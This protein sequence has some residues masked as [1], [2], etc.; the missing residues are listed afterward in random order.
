MLI[1]KRSTCRTCGEGRRVPTRA[2]SYILYE[3]CILDGAVPHRVCAIGA[4][5]GI[6]KK[7]LVLRSWLARSGGLQGA[8]GPGCGPGREA[9]AAR[10]D[11]ARPL[12][13]RSLYE[14]YLFPRG[15]L[16]CAPSQRRSLNNADSSGEMIASRYRTTIFFFADPEAES[17]RR[18]GGADRE[19]SR[20][21][22]LAPRDVAHGGCLV[23]ASFADCRTFRI[24]I[25]LR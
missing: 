2:L 22:C 13:A 24:T 6:E 19:R 10:D 21:Q 23:C 16:A 12:L 25:G 18:G 8:R 11:G 20:E 4:I 9:R 1:E 5:I 17:W 14:L 7:T 3:A 15:Q